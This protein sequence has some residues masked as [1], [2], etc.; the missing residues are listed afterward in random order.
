MRP[1]AIAMIAST[2]MLGSMSSYGVAEQTSLQVPQSI[3]HQHEQIVSRL[4]AFAKEKG[5]VGAA[6]S[7]A[8]VFLKDH[9][10]KEQAFVLPPLG[11]LSRIAK[12][13]VSKDMEPAIAMADRARAALSDF[14]K[15]HAQITSLMNELIEAGENSRNEELVQ[16]ATWIASQSLNDMEVVQP[17]VIIIGNYVR[18]KLSKGR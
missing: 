15:D 6:A 1:I 18:E 7:K 9:Y 12:G 16:L 11:L 3:R 13:E 4:A 17:T 10:A 2:M 5:R 14:Q 8:L